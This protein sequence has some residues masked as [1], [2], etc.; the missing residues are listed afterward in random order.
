MATIDQG[1]EIVTGTEAGERQ[2]DGSW[3]EGSVN[4][5]VDRRLCEMT[6]IASQFGKEEKKS[7]NANEG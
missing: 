5:L 7:D 3:P 4:A 6:E 1:I 2:A